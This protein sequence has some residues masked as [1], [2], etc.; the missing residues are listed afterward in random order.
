MDK[1]KVGLPPPGL[2]GRILSCAPFSSPL[3]LRL[4]PCLCCHH[5]LP[6]T[7]PTTFP[8]PPQRQSLSAMDQGLLETLAT[9]TVREIECM[10]QRE[11]GAMMSLE[12][13]GALAARVLELQSFRA[14]ATRR[15]DPGCIKIIA[16][17]L[18]GELR[19][20]PT[21]AR[22]ERDISLNA[23]P[24]LCRRSYHPCDALRPTLLV[25]LCVCAH[26]P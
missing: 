12:L 24:R 14:F 11:D 25:P 16:E 2:R 26:R 1:T 6:T 5:H 3:L 9:M 4:P 23:L 22:A 8:S 15:V 7:S 19:A 18:T 13:E 20:A 21:P 17:K 10:P